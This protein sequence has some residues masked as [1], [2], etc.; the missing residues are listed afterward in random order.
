MKR[1]YLKLDGPSEAAPAL[2]VVSVAEARR[3]LAELIDR[4][5]AGEVVVISRRGRP[6]VRLT[7]ER[8]PRHLLAALWVERLQQM[9]ERAGD[10]GHAS[11]E[12]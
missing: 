2:T 4:V 8:Q 9:H 11:R 6:V 5:L 10:A 12:V 3:A 7:A 1:D